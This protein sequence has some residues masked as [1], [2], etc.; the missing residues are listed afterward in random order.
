MNDSI[1]SKILNLPFDGTLGKFEGHIL[2]Y[3]FIGFILGVI[4]GSIIRGI[5]KL[6]IILVIISCITLFALLVIEEQNII[7]IILFVAFGLGTVIF[8][9]LSKL[10]KPY[11]RRR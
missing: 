3:V 11:I 6:A 2:L 10:K 4:I 9:I 1:V 5:I 7:L 8:K